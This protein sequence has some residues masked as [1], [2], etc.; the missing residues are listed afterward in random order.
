M[1]QL[2]YRTNDR[3]FPDEPLQRIFAER[4][5]DLMLPDMMPGKTVLEGPD[6]M[7]IDSDGNIY[8]AMT[9]Q[10]RCMVFNPKGFPTGEILIPERYE[11]RMLKSTHITIQPGTRTGYICTCDMET[12]EAALYRA[13]VDAAALPGFAF[14]E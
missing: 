5:M 14:S 9:S 1:E 11:G 13:G 8:V 2:N 3:T 6:S 4:F 7:V 12:G 10:G